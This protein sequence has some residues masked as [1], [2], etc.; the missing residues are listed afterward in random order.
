MTAP[1][2]ASA[3]FLPT[4]APCWAEMAALA[5]A[6][7]QQGRLRPLILLAGRWGQAYLADCQARGLEH[8]LLDDLQESPTWLAAFGDRARGK[9]SQWRRSP[10]A[11]AQ[12]LAAGLGRALDHQARLLARAL[13]QARP[14][15][16]VCA[17]ERVFNWELPFI[18]A[19]RTRQVPVVVPPI[20][21]VADWESLLLFRD[22]PQHRAEDYPSLAQAHP[23]QLA[24]GPGGRGKLLFYAA[25]MT[26]ALAQ[27]GLLPA[28]P[29]IPGGGPA[30][31]FLADSRQSRERFLALGADPAK[32]EVTGHRAHDQLFQHYQEGLRHK[33]ALGP[34]AAR[35]LVVALPQLAE[36][37]TLDWSDHWQEIRALA[38]M[39]TGLPGQCLISLHPRMDPARYRFLEQE[40]GL[41]IAQRPLAEV[42][43]LSHVF[44]ATYSSTVPW[45]VLCRIPPVVFDFYNFDFQMYEFLDGVRVIKDRD[46]F[47]EELARLLSDDAYYAARAGEQEPWVEYLS[48]FDGQCTQRILEA[49]CQAG[50]V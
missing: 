39:L 8:L 42:L 25:P 6:L 50:G 33:A 2:L 22:T 34:G 20:S 37:G 11:E 26:L 41:P 4:T 28:R 7:A 44:A 47:R 21:Y 1:R 23:G 16:A 13:E 35:T 31:L 46:L 5:Q 17:N 49:I 43:P 30:D 40:Y 32:V 9:W 3:V 10:L 48:P 29:W 38:Q 12:A 45:A 27:R 18:Q 15:V 19:C 36:Q 14:V 24:P